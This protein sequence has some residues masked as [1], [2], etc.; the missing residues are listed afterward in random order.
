[1]VTTLQ[2]KLPQQGD[3]QKENTTEERIPNNDDHEL[4]ARLL[5]AV[6]VLA[7]ACL[8]S[9]KELSNVNESATTTQ[10]MSID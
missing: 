4:L 7:D 8:A 5:I 1:V 2:P 6:F 10:E 3:G 9:I